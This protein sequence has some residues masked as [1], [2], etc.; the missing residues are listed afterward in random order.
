MAKGGG[1]LLTLRRTRKAFIVE[2]T[3]GF[4]LIFLLGVLYVRGVRLT[5]LANSFVLGMAAVSIGAVEL[6]R[7]FVRYTFTPSK[8]VITHGLIKQQK[9]NVYFHPLAYVP[10]INMKQSRLQRLL[11]YGTIYVAGQGDA[12]I[13]IKDVDRPHKVL[14]FVEELVNKSQGQQPSRSEPKSLLNKAV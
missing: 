12:T 6:S 4:I 1:H 7:L 2:Y 9:K 8:L 14:Q 3:C 13:Q 10:D 5:S 11:N